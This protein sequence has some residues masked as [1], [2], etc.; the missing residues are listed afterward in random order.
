LLPFG[1]AHSAPEASW[2]CSISSSPSCWS[3]TA[4]LFRARCFCKVV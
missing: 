2:Y 1:C 4:A 3:C